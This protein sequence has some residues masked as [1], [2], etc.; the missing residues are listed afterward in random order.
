[1][2][3]DVPVRPGEIVRQR[4]T[5]GELPDGGPVA[6]PV[7][8][9]GGT[10]PGPTLYVQ[11]GIHGDELTGIAIC[12]E[13]LG[14]LE[15]NSIAGTVVAVPVANVPSFLTRT[16]GFLHE[17]RWLIDINRIFP[18]NPHGLM[19]ERIADALMNQ[20]A[21][22]ADL[23]IDLHSALAGCDIAP[24][25][26]IDPD[27]DEDGTLAAR[28]R[29]GLAYGTPYAYYKRRGQMF[30]T[31]DLSRSFSAQAEKAG[32]VTISAE[33]GESLRVSWDRMPSGVQ[34]IRNVMIAMGML[35]EE[36]VVGEPARRFSA[37]KLVHANR[38]GGLRLV[39]DLGS[40]V[41][42][43]QEIGEVVDVF[44]E[45]IE[46][47]EAPVDGFILRAMRYGSIS[48]GAEVVWVAS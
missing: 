1:M 26:Y 13:A 22:H 35:D 23:T 16:R 21:R 24:F 3:L 12:R 34:G 7:V 47:L 37:I 38:G 32:I 6:L 17:E 20:F 25:V 42:A 28:E 39:V 11:A 29:Y 31:S 9:I 2:F 40:E 18:G 48:S 43:G 8:T 5:I 4:V 44:G 41:V 19:T 33:V 14:G 30:G 36:P 27:D 45:R 10:R 15:P 46:R